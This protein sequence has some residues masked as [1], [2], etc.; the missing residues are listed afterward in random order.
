MKKLFT[1]LREFQTEYFPEHQ[2]F[3]EELAHGQTPRVLFITCSDS[4]IDPALITQT[5]VGDLFVIRNAGNIIPAF[6]SANGGEGAA[7]EYALQA[8]NISQIVVCGH[9]HCGAM[10][11]LLKLNKLQEDMP[12][13]YDWLRH[14]DATRQLLKDNY[15]HI[16]GEELI[17]VAIAENVLTQLDNLK[18][19]PA[20]RAKL[21]RGDLALYGWVYSIETGEVLAFDPVEHAFIPPQ[22]RLDEYWEPEQYLSTTAPPV[23]KDV[24]RFHCPNL[25]DR[26]EDPAPKKTLPPIPQAPWVSREQA[27]RIYR[28]SK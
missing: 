11:G 15:S 2:A 6:G 7:V 14:T 12:L 19:Y 5:D 4:R 24:W 3:F 10:K 23:P 25:S 27:E 28:G 1:G 13:V 26:P 8:L 22:S 18:T 21:Q 20:V 9:S 16:Q 17:E